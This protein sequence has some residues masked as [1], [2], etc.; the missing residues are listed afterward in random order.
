VTC[1]LDVLDDVARGLGGGDPLAI[2]RGLRCHLEEGASGPAPTRMVDTGEIDDRR[3]GTWLPM[4][5]FFRP[6][7]DS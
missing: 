1:L 2:H 3:S 4:V 7:M 5:T 6:V